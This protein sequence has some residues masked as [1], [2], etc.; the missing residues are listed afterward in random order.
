MASEVRG[1]VRDL[2][3]TWDVEDDE[4][5]ASDQGLL[6][7]VN[8]T[9]TGPVEPLPPD[10]GDLIRLHR[11][12][13]LRRVTTIMEFGVGYSTLV[14][15]HALAMN[16]A[17]FGPRVREEMRR[18]NAFELHSIDDISEYLEAAAGLLPAEL[19]GR[20]TFHESSCRMATFDGRI[21]TFYDRL[22]NICPDLIYLDGP[23]QNSVH[24]DVRGISTRSPDRLP[25]S[26]D[27]LAI[28]HFL[29]PGTLI[30]VDGRTANARFLNANLQRNWAYEHFPDADV[31]TFEMVERPLG[32]HNRRQVELCLG[33]DWPGLKSD[34]Q[35]AQ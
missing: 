28:E 1:T 17:E 35:Q 18:A 34:V 13:R 3:V 8:Q 30:L 23:G 27:I 4:R 22:P 25:M 15:A 7:L 33:V 29:L 12:V 11:L 9:V 2:I 19:E 16:E 32:P 24:G 5:Y 20:V 26:G 14:M 10:W 31:H 6:E 21:C